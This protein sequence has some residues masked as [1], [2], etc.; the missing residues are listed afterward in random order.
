MF[1][2]LCPELYG[3]LETVFGDVRI[4][5]PGEELVVQAAPRLLSPW[6]E[7][8][9]YEIISAGEYYLV[10]C[11][12]CGDTRK[13]LEI[14]HRWAKFPALAHC[15]NE[16][17]LT[18]PWRM[19][20]LRMRVLGRARPFE[21]RVN[22]G[23]REAATL[24]PVAPPGRVLP[25]SAL[26]PGHP[27]CGYVRGRGFDPAYL[28]AQF[29]VGFCEAVDNPRHQLLVGR[30][31][32]PAVMR[33]E[34]VGWQGRYLGDLDWKRAGLPKYFTM[35]GMPKRLTLY[36]YDRAARY[37]LVV[38]REGVTDVWATGPYA[39][40]LLGK[41]VTQWQIQ[42]LAKG[43][44]GKPV[45]LGLDGGVDPTADPRFQDL[46]L[47]VEHMGG[48]LVVQRLPDDLDPG[49]LS[50]EANWDF[51]YAA[52]ATAGVRVPP[53]PPPVA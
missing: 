38:V 18:R 46:K 32:C 35:P 31:Y 50:P 51:I 44:A 41:S 21:Q 48:T 7:D 29:G 25:L 45:V 43:W 3:R 8:S 10:D 47:A 42:L 34:L 14:N 22:P 23:T 27:A 33:G 2:P 12:Y 9:H 15:F 49:E 19:D 1:R 39:V 24:G 6:S 40:A 13:R 5:N 37:P 4:S 11:P 53:D 20:E 52:C 26:P 36:N 16:P 17:C 30:L 28:A